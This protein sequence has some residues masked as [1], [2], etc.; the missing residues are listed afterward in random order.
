M[1]SEL[2]RCTNIY[3]VLAW[4][5][6]FLRACEELPEDK[7]AQF[8]EFLGKY[9]Y[10]EFYGLVKELEKDYRIDFGYELEYAEYN[11]ENVSKEWWKNG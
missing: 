5:L 3:T 7:K 9:A 1:E 4:S 8:K 2:G 6:D 10:R 11:Q